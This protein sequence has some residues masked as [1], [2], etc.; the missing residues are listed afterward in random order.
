[1]KR[2][3]LLKKILAGI[4]NVSFKDLVRLV[5]GYGFVL[6]RVNGSHHIFSNPDIHEIINLQNVKGQAKPYQVKQFL[7]LLEK[8]NLRLK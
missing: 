1:M 8:Y 3:K 4:N 7:A 6:E 5:E 2:E